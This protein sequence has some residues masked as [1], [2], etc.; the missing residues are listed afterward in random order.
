[1]KN[2]KNVFRTALLFTSLHFSSLLFTGT[3]DAEK[4]KAVLE[5]ERFSEAVT[6]FS[7]AVER[8]ERQAAFKRFSALLRMG[9]SRE[10]IQ[11]LSEL[12]GTQQLFKMTFPKGIDWSPVLSPDG[13]QFVYLGWQTGGAV[14]SHS[15]LYLFDLSEGRETPLTAKEFDCVSPQWSP[16]G[17]HLLFESFRTDTNGDGRIT[18]QDRRSLWIVEVSTKKERRV[19]ND[20]FENF[21]PQWM[22]DSRAI[23]WLS[24]RT[25]MNGDGTVDRRDGMGLYRLELTGGDPNLLVDAAEGVPQGLERLSMMGPS[26]RGVSQPR[27]GPGGHWIVFN[28]QQGGHQILMAVSVASHERVRLTP[29]EADAEF[30]AFQPDGRGVAAFIKRRDTNGDGHVDAF[31]RAAVMVV[32]LDHPQG[33]RQVLSDEEEYG[34]VL[35]SPDGKN[36]AVSRVTRAAGKKASGGVVGTG[37]RG[38]AI[39]SLSDPKGEPVSI[40]GQVNDNDV[41]AFY[42]DGRKLLFQS[43]RQDTNGD[44]RIDI[45]DV[46]SLY[47]VDVA[48]TPLVRMSTVIRPNGTCTRVVELVT[49]P[50]FMETVKRHQNVFSGTKWQMEFV[51]GGSYHVKIVGEFA[52]PAEMSYA[53][54]PVSW[55]TQ[56][57]WSALVSRY[58]ER[59]LPSSGEGQPESPVMQFAAEMSRIMSRPLLLHVR[60]TVP[61]ASLKTNGELHGQTAEWLIPLQEL[62]SAKREA[63]LW[64]ETESR[65]WP[66]LALLW[67][68]LFVVGGGGGYRW[69]SGHRAER[70]RQSTLAREYADAH[71]Y[72]GLALAKKGLYDDALV[73]YQ[74]ALKHGP[75]IGSIHLHAASA[76]ALKGDA[77]KAREAL[78]RALKWDP[79][80]SPVASASPELKNIEVRDKG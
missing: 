72:L 64:V 62:R 25:D 5:V 57:T 46:A 40:V 22:P 41:V 71:Q 66:V 32:P 49:D 50:L 75:S 80:L 13:T 38:I 18:K 19:V 12:P 42:P 20:Q 60:V 44:G 7:Q 11:R 52:S 67:V 59:L 31:D 24:P 79:S 56:R 76:Y 9:P 4:G 8:G 77:K 73:E 53:D 2:R 61:G 6:A 63:E 74:E 51:E 1:M 68:G 70:S 15:I 28:R 58:R 3:A 26:E 55:T 69:W 36:L 14:S 43:W 45:L 47:L 21:S 30:A 39:L 37:K 27:V 65:N 16:D 54:S 23:V 33:A 35:F 10:I 48:G 29:T 34:T 78:E 17:R